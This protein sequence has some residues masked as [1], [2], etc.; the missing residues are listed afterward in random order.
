MKSPLS[1]FTK[2]PSTKRERE[3]Y[4]HTAIEEILNGD[5]NPLQIEVRLKNLEEIIKGIRTST[6]LKNAIL[7]EVYRYPEKTFEAYGARI[8]KTTRREW[9][10]DECNDSILTEFKTQ[11]TDLQK[12]IKDRETFL[13]TLKPG[14]IAVDEATGQ[15]LQP[16]STTEKTILQIS[17]L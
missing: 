10:F 16:P 15:Q 11:L 9:I 17:I 4:I 1:L 6:T 12:A 7:D 3:Y 14:M 5:H 13:Q 8:T 2:F